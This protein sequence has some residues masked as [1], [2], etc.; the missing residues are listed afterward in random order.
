M[1]L[2]YETPIF[3]LVMALALGTWLIYDCL[4][5]AKPAPAPAEAPACVCR[6]EPAPCRMEGPHVP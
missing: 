6:C 1:R 5:D 4:G 2:S 3:E